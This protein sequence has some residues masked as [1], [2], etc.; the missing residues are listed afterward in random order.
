MKT[1]PIQST[2][3]IISLDVLRGFAILGILLL[4]IQHY[5]MITAAYMNPTAYGD[6]IGINKLVWIFSH[7][8]GEQKFWS[9]FSIL[10]GAGVVLFTNRLKEKG[11]NSI[12]LHYRRTLWLLIIGLA[13]AYL[14]WYG[15]ILVAYAISGLWVVLLRKVKPINLVIIGLSLFSVASILYLIFGMTVPYWPEENTAE[16]MKGWLPNIEQIAK[17]LETYRS[18]WLE[19][20]PDRS[21]TSIMMQTIVFLIQVGWRT[22]GLMLIGMALYKWGILSAEKSKAFYIKMMLFGLIPGLAIVYYGMT[23]NFEA[24]FS[25]EYSMFVGSQYNYWGSLLVTLGYIGAVVLCVKL[26]LFSF[27]KNSL[28]AVGQ[29]AL[30][31]YLVQT[32][33]CTTIFYGH[34]FGLY[35]KLERIEQL[36]IVF[37]IWIIQIT[38]SPIWLKYYRYGPFEWLWRSL[39]YWKVQPI[40]Q[41]ELPA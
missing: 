18:G 15:D 20:M 16:A 1:Q 30:T 23:T 6:L 26:N 19:Q 34:G 17:E 14:L 2:E 29:M 5:S 21:N 24:N 31:N 37:A 13:H 38:Y 7:V 35:G 32:L 22:G 25:I 11:I 28:R 39:T 9:L 3:R 12:A 10:F 41:N 33:I 4:N 8:L 27:I 40:K 36:L